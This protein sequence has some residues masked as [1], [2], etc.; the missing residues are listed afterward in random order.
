MKNI[1]KIGEEINKEKKRGWEME[2]EKNIIKYE[3]VREIIEVERE[4]KVIK[5]AKVSENLERKSVT[6]RK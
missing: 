6:N 1:I 2:T 3:K 5:Y 4:W